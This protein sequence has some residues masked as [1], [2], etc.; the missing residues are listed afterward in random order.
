M[1]FLSEP[2]G[3][4]SYRATDDTTAI[5]RLKEGVLAYSVELAG[6]ITTRANI[7]LR[8]IQN[9]SPAAVLYTHAGEQS[10][11]SVD[12]G[13]SCDKVKSCVAREPRL[14]AESEE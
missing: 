8:Y 3:R 4:T 5:L 13:G 14:V 12:M 9:A 11:M 1:L 7:P 6:S 2:S 10:A